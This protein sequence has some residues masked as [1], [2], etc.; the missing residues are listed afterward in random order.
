VRS[1]AKA[2]SAGSTQRRAAGLGRTFRGAMLT[3]LALL[4]LAIAASPAGARLVHQL[5]P[6]YFGASGSGDGQLE[7]GERSGVAI[8]E[9]THDVYVADT[10]NHRIDKF[11]SAGNFIR[12]F[13][14]DVG[15]AGVDV[16]T[17][18]C[19]AGTPGSAPGALEAPTFI[20][21]DNSAGASKG[22]VYVADA[23]TNV[24]S[25]FHADGT[26]VS[27]WGAGGQI[28]GSSATDGPFDEL[29]GEAVAIA[30]IAVDSAG[31]LFVLQSGFESFIFKFG[32]D[33]SFTEDFRGPRGTLPSGFAVNPAGEFFKVNGTQTVE[34]LAA[35]GADVGQVGKDESETFPITGL[36]ADASN[37]DLYVGLGSSIDNYAFGPSGEVIGSSCIPASFAGCPPTANFGGGGDLTSAAGLA[38]DGT[39]HDVYVADDGGGR[40]A[41]FAA[42]LLPDAITEAATEIENDSAVLHGTLSAAGGP[43]A[44]C[45]FQYTTK[46]AFESEG[47]EGATSAPCSPAGPFSGSGSV[48][49]SAEAVGLN[50]GSEYRFRIVASNENGDNPGQALG[51]MTAGPTIA[52]QAAEAIGTSDVVLS[53]T[54][55]PKGAK[56]T[57]HVEYGTTPAY[58][59]STP[60]VLPIG[61]E[62]DETLHAVSVHVG[63]LQAGTAYHFRFV[64]T[65]PAGS[66]NGA[67]T[68]FA[69]HQ[70]IPSFA[71]CA[72]DSLRTGFGSRLSDCRAYEQATPID[73]HGSNVQG[74]TNL[75]QASS[76]GNRVTFYVIGGLPTTG[77]ATTFAP[78][79]AS[80]DGAGWS[81]DGTLPQADQGF[82]ALVV[83]WSDDLSASF[84]TVSTPVSGGTGFAGYLRD[85][86]TAAF[87]LGFVGSQDFSG[88]TYLAGFAADTSHAIFE[89]KA[90]LAPGAAPGQFNLYD[91]DHGAVT[92]A[93]RIPAG[94]ATS[95][96]DAGGPACVPAPDGS[97]A[98]PYAWFN[99][100]A[101]LTDLGGALDDYYTRNTISRDGSRVFFTTRKAG[102]LYV[103]E[104]GTGT[105]RISASQRTVPDPN[106]EKPAA[107]VAATPDGSKVFFLS[108][109]KLTDDSTAVSTAENSCVAGP[110]GQDLYSYDVDSGELTDL[111]VDSNAGDAKGAAVRG[112]L[113]TSVDGSYVYFMANGVLAPGAT[114]GS[115]PD[116]DGFSFGGL[117]NLYVSHAGT[118]TF[119]ATLNAG[120]R[121]SDNWTPRLG[122]DLRQPKISR[123][124]ADGRTLLFSSHRSH[125]GY[126]NAIETTTAANGCVAGRPGNAG[127]PCAEF[128]R[129]SAPEEELT[130]VS[131]NPTGVPPAGD[132]RLA[133]VNDFLFATPPRFSFLTRNL[134]ADGARVFFESRDALLPTDTNGV[135]DVY[136]WEAKGS[137]SCESE[138]QNGG[139]LYL[140]SS[141]T[142]PDASTFGDASADGDHAFIFT[143]QQ[144]VPGDRDELVDIYDAGVGAGLAAQHALAP[145]TCSGVACQANPAPPPDQ[146]AAS[147]NF[148][149][150]G[151]ARKRPVARKCPKGK[152]KVRRAGKVRCQKASKAKQHKRH[153]NRGGS[154]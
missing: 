134:S 94:S 8:D 145:P 62:G 34:K 87:Q 68:G 22:D 15:G 50:G 100:N 93:G 85:S 24:V 69:T 21:V 133:S 101:N 95:C 11:D 72:N 153:T 12:A 40:I 23:A 141:G 9:S 82:G 86:D 65:N 10:G 18:G 154:K 59:Q 55:N 60:E 122:G 36:A 124:S 45:E 57:Y 27:T 4:A 67:D 90:G 53:A 25:K 13:G 114:P 147:A 83:G 47:F 73:K 115:C 38:V 150:P 132:A 16:C 30:G 126:D 81:T 111:T 66:T 3:V 136:Q 17:S 46:A 49:V 152:R 48:A 19:V 123:V 110:Q 70:V 42:T 146:P 119:I 61:F 54:I 74:S 104:D 118:T 140:L 56:T 32:Q 14:A 102:Q 29:E 7:L 117:C 44:S 144:L 31:N 51:F 20:A 103:R 143:S 41:I 113:G 137:G 98:G 120:R 63:G 116:G 142:S 64:A 75:I 148:F 130:C 78:F 99:G 43:D 28:D 112:V 89:S 77:G 88:E 84:S 97:F 39:S 96:D 52:A 92:L 76:A 108:C 121:D 6:A 129:Y 139:C 91:L 138:S 1:H 2:S 131:C 107:F 58:G 109:E 80:R 79:I 33:G 35:S 26:L 127:E 71:P 125:T 105:T 135:N 37:G 128:F 5:P 149:G 106:G 151:N